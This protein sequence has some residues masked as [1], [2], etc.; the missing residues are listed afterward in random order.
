MSSIEN[1][2]WY[3]LPAHRRRREG[4]R[5]ASYQRQQENARING[6]GMKM[7]HAAAYAYL[8]GDKLSVA[9]G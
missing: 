5:P 8:G 9:R 2:A 3:I 4:A 6:F 7:P 1:Q